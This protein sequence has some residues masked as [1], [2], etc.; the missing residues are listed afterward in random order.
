MLFI[1]DERVMKEQTIDE[2]RIPDD[3]SNLQKEN[4]NIII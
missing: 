1:C 2:Q 3:V 4:K